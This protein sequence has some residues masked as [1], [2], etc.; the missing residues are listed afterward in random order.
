MIDRFILA[1]LIMMAFQL[2]A[3]SFYVSKTGNDSNNGSSNSPWLTIQY[4]VNQLNAGDT[5]SVHEGIYNESITF[6]N[7][8]NSING[9]IVIRNIENENPVIDGTGLVQSIDYPQGLIRIFDKNYLKIIGFEIR[10]LIT[11]IPNHFPAGIWISGSSNHIELLNNSV[12]SI[13]QNGNDAGA[14]GIAVYGTNSTSSINNIVIDGNEIYNCKLGWS[15][16]LVLNGNVEQFVI[17]NNIIRDNNNIAFDF[18]GHEGVCP[19]PEFD[20][21]RNGIVAGN[22]AYNI[23]S[24]GNPAYGTDASAGGIYIDGGKNIIIE[25]N[26]VY[27]CNL[28]IEIA[29]EHQNKSTSGIILRNNFIHHND[30][31][32][33]SFGGYD[34]LR[35]ITEQCFIVNNTFILN[36][37]ENFDWGAEMLMQY[38]CINNVI[39]NNIVLG[40]VNVPLLSD[41]TG[42][43]SGN[44][45]NYNLY[46]CNGLPLW[47]WAGLSINSFLEYQSQ[48]TQEANSLF[49][50]PLFVGGN[51]FSPQIEE[52]SPVK[53]KGE[54]IGNLIIGE[55][56][57]FLNSR[58]I[59]STVDIGSVEISTGTAVEN[60]NKTANVFRMFLINYPNP[61]N[62]TT[63]IRYSIPIVET[64]SGAS[65]RNVLLKVYDVLGKE[66]ATLVNEKKPAGDY[67]I[68]WNASAFPSG[69][70]FYRL[71]ADSFNKV[72]KMILT[73]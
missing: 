28:G 18:I 2:N 8:G 23:D 41:Q 64:H 45:F 46:Y 67:E 31:V 72:M 63:K 30:A 51:Y 13:E 52:A 69:V 65:V 33:L 48:S 55:K 24:R 40:S 53:D 36:N 59:G 61:F 21:A 62:P 34:E 19:A 3:A 60:E 73:K 6:T 7:S 42:T 47:E 70:Y 50:D 4:A 49:S 20:Q 57:F 35:G 1:S 22:T 71:Q 38:Y 9:F 15:E 16:S 12:H 10:N 11:S 14:H 58:I 29:S 26:E 37:Y 43:G 54:N 27:N 66:V 39:K 68:E 32:G 44:I 5:L 17:R 56:D 25:R